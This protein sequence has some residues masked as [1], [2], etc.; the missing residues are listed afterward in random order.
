MRNL[1]D[2]TS[3]SLIGEADLIIAIAPVQFDG[4]LIG[5]VAVGSGK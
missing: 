2:G 5:Y 1:P 4:E 3:A